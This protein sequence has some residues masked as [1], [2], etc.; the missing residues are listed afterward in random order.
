[1]AKQAAPK[2]AAPKKAAPKKEAEKTVEPAT[3]RKP[4][5]K[6]VKPSILDGMS[7]SQAK[8]HLRKNRHAN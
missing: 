2:K 3:P 7:Q 6:K 1:M 5:V 8:K 4:R